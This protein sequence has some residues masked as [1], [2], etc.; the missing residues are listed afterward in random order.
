MKI[1][2][3]GSLIGFN[4]SR[5]LYLGVRNEIVKQGNILTRDWVTEEIKGVVT[6]IS[7]MM[8]LTKKA[9]ENSD[10]VII[11][12]TNSVA[13]VGLQIRFSV[14]RGLPSL[15]LI[16]DDVLET[17]LLESY[18]IEE[19]YHKYIKVKK[20]DVDSLEEIISDFL[21]WARTNRKIVRFNLEIEKGQD[22]YLKALAKQNKTSKSE[23][24][25]SLI[26]KEMIKNHHSR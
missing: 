13:S 17:A 3:G 2:F 21:Y 1:F 20:Y 7:D 26:T 15:V 25:R 14:E 9:I 11:E 22:D 16:Q 24:I 12:S 10:A 19:K 8:I 18:F 4:K 6:K 5:D 23:E